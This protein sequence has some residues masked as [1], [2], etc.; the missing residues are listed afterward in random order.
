[1]PFAALG[2]G[3]ALL[4]SACEEKVVEQEVVVR[5]VKVHTIGKADAS[6]RRE[7]PGSIR[8]FQHADMGFEVSGRITEFYATEGNDVVQGE[9]LA[10][11]DARDY[12]ANLKATQANLRK[13]Q[14]DL[15][16]INSIY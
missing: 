5:P 2:V 13:A 12:E 10:I 16:R 6:S 7:Y 9:V 4:A 3:L 8:A 14:A 15:K 11:L 1:L